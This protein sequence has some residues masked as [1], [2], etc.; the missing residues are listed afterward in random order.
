LNDRQVAKKAPFFGMRIGFIQTTV[1]AHQPMIGIAGVYPDAMVVYVLVFLASGYECFTA[2]SA[3]VHVSV[4]SKNFIDVLGVTEYFLVVVAAR[5][6]G[7][8]LGPILAFIGRSENTP[9]AVPC[10]YNCI[11][12]V[13]IDR[14]DCKAYTAHI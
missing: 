6:E 7:S 9:L 1:A 4:H 3:V 13:A 10:L 8:L 14:R 11:H 5:R 12:H 2:V